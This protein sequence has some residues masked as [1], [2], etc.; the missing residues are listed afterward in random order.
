[1]STPRSNAITKK[2]ES[3]NSDLS[4]NHWNPRSASQSELTYE[5][6]GIAFEFHRPG[7]PKY[8]ATTGS[9]AGPNARKGRWTRVLS[10]QGRRGDRHG[11]RFVVLT[12]GRWRWND[13]TFLKSNR[14]Y[15][16]L[17]RT[18]LCWHYYQSIRIQSTAASISLA[19]NQASTP[20]RLDSIVMANDES[21]SDG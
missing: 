8:A 21:S 15:V 6:S 19:G 10:R 14:E 20:T 18:H 4:V 5:R 1:M 17:K 13:K 7:T 12:N 11:W 16:S 9:L 3:L 2:N